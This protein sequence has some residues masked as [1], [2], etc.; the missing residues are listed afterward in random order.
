M[1]LTKSS[2]N[3]FPDWLTQARND[4]AFALIDKYAGW[5][6]FDVV[7]KLRRLVRIRKIGH[8]GTLDPL[9]T[10]LLILCFN[11]FTK[12]I[13]EFTNLGKNYSAVIKLGAT[14]PS[15]DR[16]KEEENLC[17][18]SQISDDDIKNTLNGFRGKIEQLPPIYS[19]KWQ[20]GERLY[21][22]ARDGREVDIKP[23]E[24]EISELY[25][26]K[27]EKPFI[28]ID[29]QCSKGTYIRAI[30]RDI[31]KNLGCGAYLFDLRRTHIGDY[32]VEDALTID[33]FKELTTETE[34][35]SL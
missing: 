4:G 18:I 32:N 25:L 5:T 21:H 6:S 22:F 13:N 9:A 20:N 11:R 10:G 23:V 26:L 1:I 14:T 12:K 8:T 29:V 35:E 16:E 15:D 19:A 7:A 30:A 28:E 31:G 24:V 34:N 33:D 17:D 2:L 27:I 3:N